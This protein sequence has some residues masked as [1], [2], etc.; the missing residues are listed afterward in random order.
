MQELIVDNLTKVFT[1]GQNEHVVLQDICFV[2]NKG[3]FLSIVGPSG[4]GKTTLLSIIAGFTKATG[5]KI[6]VGTESVSKPGPDRAF[7]FQSYAL[8]P[9]MNIRDNIT[10]P[11]KQQRMPS[12]ERE[13]RLKELLGLAGL[14][15]KE[16]LYPHQLSGGMQQRTAVIRALAC[17]PRLL[18]M[19]EP[20]GAVDVQ[21]R[22]KLQNDLEDIFIRD[23]RTV[24]MVTHD[25]EEAV[26]MSD[27]VIVMSNEQGRIVG[28]ISISLP[29]PRNRKSQPYF[30][31]VSNL[32]DIL[33]DAQRI[34]A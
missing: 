18:L 21:M 27:R 12:G 28:D 11:M 22:R 7:V 4:C 15:G 19:D 33:D 10:Y 26:F 23:P 2:V 16:A 24:V 5:G 31:M 6:T 17:R 34:V 8:F 13:T 20:L 1:N 30:A 25:I 3:E 14:E 9:W 29:R 32:S